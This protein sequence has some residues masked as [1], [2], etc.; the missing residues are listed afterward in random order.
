MT[1]KHP[2]KEVTLPN[3]L[4]VLVYPM[5][6][7]MSVHAVLYV[8]VGAVYEKPELRGI[9]HFTEHMAFLGTK[10]F[11]SPL[12]F[13]QAVQRYGARA[14]GFTSRFSTR[15]WVSLPYSNIAEGIDL[16]NQ[17]AF[18]PLIKNEDVNKE[19]G[20]ILSEYN[21]FWHNPDRKFSYES[22]RKIFKQKEHP[23]G[24]HVFGTP[25]TI[26]AI[27]K[28]DILSW[29]KKYYSPT[30]MILSIAGNVKADQIIK[31][32]EKKIGKAKQG[33]KMTE[34]EFSTKD[35][36]TF[37]IFHQKESRPQ[38]NFA[39]SFPA[40][41][42]KEFERKKRLKIRLLNNIFGVGWASRLFQKLREKQRLVYR[43]RSSTILLNW[44]GALEIGGSVPIAKLIPAMKSLKEEIDKIKATG[45]SQKEIDLSRNHMNSLTLM[46]FDNPESI[47]YYFGYQ[48]FE[49]EKVW[50]PED[51]MR[52]INKV[53]KPELDQLAQEIF[54]YSKVNISLM[55][56][57]PEK[58][59]KT[60]E[61]I[62]KSN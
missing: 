51:Y 21:D 47:A 56:E 37:S 16:I 11:P 39:L 44:M 26:K 35:Y 33:V 55:G 25:N 1:K 18:E 19:K 27:K 29:R 13:S 28:A 5:E 45:V 58:T 52:E 4:R 20:V 53:K 48:V 46:R 17:L 31:I 22:W 59:L 15:Y 8:K 9:S 12:T 34:P 2:Y 43:I 61:E 38:I 36:S 30:N 54:D 41:G 10:K 62:F 42:R 23:Y 14:N 60:V 3:K 7:V 40:F 32:V 6:S 50:F 57:V 49:E 24:L